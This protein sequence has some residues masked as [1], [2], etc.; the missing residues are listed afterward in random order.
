MPSKSAGIGVAL[1]V[2]VGATLGVAIALGQ[3]MIIENGIINNS[4]KYELYHIISS[5]YLNC[6]QKVINYVH[7]NVECEECVP[8]LSC[9]HISFNHRC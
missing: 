4:I 6:L 9:I 5:V 7:D 1:G 8:I 2:A 3:I